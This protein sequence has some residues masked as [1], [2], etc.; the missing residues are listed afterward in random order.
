MTAP[1][2]LSASQIEE[3]WRAAIDCMMTHDLGYTGDS[4]SGYIGPMGDWPAVSGPTGD[5]TLT[6]PRQPGNPYTYST[7]VNPWNDYYSPWIDAIESLFEPWTWLPDPTQFHKRALKDAVWYLSASIPGKGDG[8]KSMNTPLTTHLADFWKWLS[9]DSAQAMSAATL[10]T[11]DSIYGGAKIGSILENLRLG[12]VALGLALTAER[13]LWTAARNDVLNL[14]KQAVTAFKSLDSGGAQALE[15]STAMTNLLGDFV[16]GFGIVSD[17]LGAISSALPKNEDS[18]TPALADGANTADDVFDNLQKALNTTLNDKITTHEQ[19][20]QHMLNVQLNDM[21]DAK[22]KSS[23]HVDPGKG[24]NE[25]ARHLPTLNVRSSTIRDLGYDTMSEIAAQFGHSAQRCQAGDNE[26]AWLRHGAIGLGA[27]GPYTEWS[28]LLNL[29]LALLDSNG[30]EIVEA[31]KVLARVAGY[32]TDTDGDM[33][34]NLKGVEGELKKGGLAWPK[35]VAPGTP[36]PQTTPPQ[37]GGPSPETLYDGP[38]PD[39]W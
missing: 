10:H 34:R 2:D 38:A 36:A 33:K 7:T 13:H 12:P 21:H 17:G 25:D 32:F 6:E 19:N 27:T 11:F 8:P 9:P 18:A 1:K 29:T 35:H 37:Y 14:A 16:P 15:V 3:V 39:E 31:G 4:Q 23:Y 24:V 5:I 22:K 20:I 28:A 26:F 30:K